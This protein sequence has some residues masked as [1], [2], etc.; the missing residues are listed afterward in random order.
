MLRTFHEPRYIF[1]RNSQC[2]LFVETD[3]VANGALNVTL[4]PWSSCN[5][6]V[7]QLQKIPTTGVKESRFKNPKYLVQ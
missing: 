5:T 2:S 3:I 7:I 6:K 1:V 4:I